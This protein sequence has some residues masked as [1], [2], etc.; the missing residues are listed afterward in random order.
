[1][2]DWD[3]EMED[4]TVQ[5]NGD[6]SGGAHS[7]RLSLAMS[8]KLYAFRA[9]KKKTRFLMYFW[10]CVP[11]RYPSEAKS[12]EANFCSKGMYA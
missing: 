7:Y 2:R 3:C 4:G 12:R 5:E 9:N 1:M 10:K 6:A 11:P 8:I